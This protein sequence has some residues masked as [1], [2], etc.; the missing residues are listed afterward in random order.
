MTRRRR[1]DGL[2]GLLTSMH[3]RALEGARGR[4][5]FISGHWEW[6]DNPPQDIL[7]RHSVGKRLVH[8]HK[9]ET[10]K[11]NR[12]HTFFG[13]SKQSQ[14]YYRLVKGPAVNCPHPRF[15]DEDYVP[16][17]GGTH[18]VRSRICKR[19]EFYCKGG[20]VSRK[21]RYP[22]CAFMASD[23]P[24]RTAAQNILKAW[25]EAAEKAKEILP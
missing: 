23:N 24:E 4:I 3:N 13:Y 17:R 14:R 12:G 7:D 22:T 21:I 2:G 8:L 20:S 6:D 25:A 11:G 5:V 19:C 9:G 1:S 15:T 10:W 18:S 16:T